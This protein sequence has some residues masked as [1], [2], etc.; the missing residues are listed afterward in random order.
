MRKHKRKFKAPTVYISIAHK[1]VA[2]SDDDKGGCILSK[3]D[4]ILNQLVKSNV[5]FI[6]CKYETHLGMNANVS[7]SVLSAGC[8]NNSL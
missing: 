3:W 6:I 7:V 5:S 1:K 8:E 2:S 4:V